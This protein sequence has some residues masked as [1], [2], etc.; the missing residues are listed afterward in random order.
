MTDLGAVRPFTTSARPGHHGLAE[1]IPLIG[2]SACPVSPSV[3]SGGLVI[4][5]R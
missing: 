4:E 2:L 3:A 5:F 1:R